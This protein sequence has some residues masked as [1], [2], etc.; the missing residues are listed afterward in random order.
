[1]SSSKTLPS[2]L[3][4]VILATYNMAASAQTAAAQ[5]TLTEYNAAGQSALLTDKKDREKYETSGVL[6]G[7][8]LG[9]LAGG[10]A[11]AIVSAGLGGWLGNKLHEAKM[12]HVLASELDRSQEQ[13]LALQ[14]KNRKLEQDF[15][16]LNARLEQ[17]N[18]QA[19]INPVATATST[20]CSD[21]ELVLHFRSSSKEIE[22]H[23][24]SA[25]KDFVK[26]ASTVPNATVQISGYTDRRGENAN[27]LALSQQRVAQV[28]TT[29][30]KLGLR[31]VKYLTSALGEKQPLSTE[32]NFEANFFDRRVLL[33]LV[34]NN[35][36]MI[37]QA[38]P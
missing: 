13:L 37:S 32:D 30:R 24:M 23:Y 19:S 1:M 14:E 22:T 12:S 33:R 26:L 34:N 38:Q 28:E 8:V 36:E 29:L 35:A 21:S 17:G 15:V 7:V 16:S 18:L 31:S 9:A 4:A 2:V 20:C 10:P 6:G 27:N 3:M 5:Q 11:G 25:L